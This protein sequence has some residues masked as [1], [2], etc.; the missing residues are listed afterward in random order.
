MP[1]TPPTTRSLLAERLDGSLMN[2]D[3]LWSSVVRERRGMQAGSLNLDQSRG[4]LCFLFVLPCGFVGRASQQGRQKPPLVSPLSP[5][6]PWRPRALEGTRRA[7]QPHQ[8]Q[9]THHNTPVTGF[10]VFTR[11]QPMTSTARAGLVGWWP[12][13][14]TGG[15]QKLVGWWQHCSTPITYKYFT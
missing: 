6:P 13:C 4:S 5:A 2:C 11:L 14:R 1:T 8:R 12:H 9:L 3:P 15:G 7:T 10:G